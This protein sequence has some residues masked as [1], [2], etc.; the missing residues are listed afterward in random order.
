MEI[1]NMKKMI[2]KLL[3]SKT[4]STAK[5]QKCLN[6]SYSLAVKIF[7]ML[8][9]NGFLLS[10]NEKEKVVKK[11]I[12]AKACAEI[13]NLLSEPELFVENYYLELNVNE[14]FSQDDQYFKDAVQLVIKKQRVSIAMIQRE[15]GIGYSRAA[16]LI[17][18]ME[19]LDY[20]SNSKTIP[21]IVFITQAEFDEIFKKSA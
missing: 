18:K 14:D 1:K 21:R 5:I 10:L 11:G 9:T 4:I 8:V 12:V 17:D 3:K 20:I 6:I 7:E 13:E 2:E 16:R 19:S 15:L